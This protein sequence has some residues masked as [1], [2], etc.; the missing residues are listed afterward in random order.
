M[1]KRCVVRPRTSE[2]WAPSDECT[3]ARCFNQFPGKRETETETETE[4]RQ[5]RDIG[6]RERETEEKKRNLQNA[7]VK[8]Q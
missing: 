8:R 2:L 5:R 7:T 3:A 6:E 4:E 1:I